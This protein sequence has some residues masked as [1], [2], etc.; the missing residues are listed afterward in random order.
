MYVSI[1]YA[2]LEGSYNFD[3]E[4]D[5]LKAFITILLIRGLF[6][7]QDDPC[8]GKILQMY[9]ISPYHDSCQRTDLMK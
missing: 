3:I 4:V 7:S 8:F 1:K 6:I 9:R 2:K 5:T